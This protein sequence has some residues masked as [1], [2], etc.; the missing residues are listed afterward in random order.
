MIEC[1]NCGKPLP[2]ALQGHIWCNECKMRDA[3]L[4]ENAN[5][6][7]KLFGELMRKIREKKDQ[8]WFEEE[9]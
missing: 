8:P 4:S 7:F 1:H 2:H 3:Q 9:K 5:R 6:E